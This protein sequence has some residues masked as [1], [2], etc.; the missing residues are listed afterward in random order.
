MVV[1][2]LSQRLEWG[3]ETVSIE[4]GRMP[5]LFTPAGSMVVWS[6]LF[7]GLSGKTVMLGTSPLRDRVGETILSPEIQVT[8]DGLLPG[9]MSTA[10]FDDQPAVRDTAAT[11]VVDVFFGRRVEQRIGVGA[12]ERG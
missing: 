5:V 6:P 1:E 10:A 8:D 11:R 9:G 7:S 4:P 3:K 2:E 12:G